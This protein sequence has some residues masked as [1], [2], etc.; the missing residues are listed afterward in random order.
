MQPATGI[1]NYSRLITDQGRLAGGVK[2]D[3]WL[4]L[5]PL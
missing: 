4:V 2:S 1:G 3:I 5:L